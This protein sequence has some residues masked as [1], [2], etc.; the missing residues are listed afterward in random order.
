MRETR[1]QTVSDIVVNVLENAEWAFAPEVALFNQVV[2]HYVVKI[3]QIIF[4]CDWLFRCERVATRF[5]LY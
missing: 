2:I 1:D 3:I 5:T 4:V